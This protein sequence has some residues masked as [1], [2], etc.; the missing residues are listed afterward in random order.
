[1]APNVVHY[2]PVV[3]TA[4]AIAFTRVLWNHWRR[5]PGARYLFWWMF[6]VAMYG[7]GTSTEAWT[8]IAGWSE[9]GFRAWYI[10]G[11]L[12]GGVVLAQGTVYLLVRRELADRLSVA[13]MTYVV[14]ASVFVVTTPLNHELVETHRLSGAVMQ[15]SWV[16]LFSPLLNIYALIFLIGGA[17]WSAWQYRRRGEGSGARATGNALIAVGALLPGIGGGFARAGWVEVLYVGELIGLILIWLGYR[18]IVADGAADSIHPI[19]RSL[20]ERNVT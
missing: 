20:A 13:I 8:T 5:A 15:W 3:S 7:A 16:R 1:M 6:G 9:I 12:L 10:T 19:Q 17:A 4:I 11:A 2:F 18:T 14:I